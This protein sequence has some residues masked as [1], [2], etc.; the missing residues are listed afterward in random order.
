MFVDVFIFFIEMIVIE[1]VYFG[2]FDVFVLV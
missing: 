2:G 1:I